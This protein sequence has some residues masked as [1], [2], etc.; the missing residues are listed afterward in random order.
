MPRQWSFAGF[1]VLLKVFVDKLKHQ[2]KATLALDDIIEPEEQKGIENEESKK[3]EIE[4]L[5]LWEESGTTY[6]TMFGCL[7]WRSTAIS[8]RVVLGIPS[9]STSRRILCVLEVG[10][11]GNGRV[12]KLTV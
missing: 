6:S 8:R 7:S 4:G 10:S 12:R 2:I 5:K 1:K 3:G 9:S 11:S